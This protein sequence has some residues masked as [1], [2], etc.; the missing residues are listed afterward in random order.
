MTDKKKLTR[1]LRRL[2][3]NFTKDSYVTKEE[4]VRDVVSIEEP[5]VRAL[6]KEDRNVSIDFD[7]DEDGNFLD[8]YVISHRL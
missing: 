1:L 3:V 2:N 7:F 5:K 6:C 4:E 8:V